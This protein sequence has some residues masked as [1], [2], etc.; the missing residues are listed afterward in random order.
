MIMKTLTSVLLALALSLGALAQSQDQSGSQ[1]G[2]Q[3][4]QN[5]QNQ[6]QSSPSNT[7]NGQ[8]MSG[9]VSQDRRIITND[10]DNK[11][12]KVDNPNS[13]KGKEG[14][15]VS[16]IVAVDPDTNTIHVIQLEEPQQ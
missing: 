12:Y 8:N 1:S 7:S 5:S 6:T 4:G 16:V 15:H 2:K 9:T 11:N 14:Q 10:R 13:L 3:S